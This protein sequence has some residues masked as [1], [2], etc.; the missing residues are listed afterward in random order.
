MALL[1]AMASD[2]ATVAS[3]VGKI[4]NVIEHSVNGIFVNNSDELRLAVEFFFDNQE[5]IGEYG[6]A[7]RKAVVA[8]FSSR[9]MVKNYCEI[10][11]YMFY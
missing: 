10:Y 11:D 2:K 1:E 7:A 5:K 6:R 8:K 9:T 3:D 4:G